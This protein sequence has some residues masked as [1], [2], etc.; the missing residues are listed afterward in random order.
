LNSLRGALHRAAA[1]NVQAATEGGDFTQAEIM[2]MTTVEELRQVNV[3][4]LAA[5]LM[6]GEL[7]QRIE[8]TSALTSHPGQYGSIREMA[9][10]QGISAAELSRTQALVNVIFPY[11][12]EHLGLPIMQVYEQIGKSNMTEL[13]PVLVCII[14]GEASASPAITQAA[15]RI[16]DD[17]AATVQAA[18]MELDNDGNYTDNDG[19]PRNLRTSVVGELLNDASHLNNREL[20]QRIRPERTSS[21]SATVTTVNGRK[22]FVAEMDEDQYTMLMRRV[23]ACTDVLFYNPATSLEARQV[24]LARVPGMRRIYELLT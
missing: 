11:I 24:E 22:L 18:G 10:D 14:T 19:N 4:D 21:I 13:I 17:T 1:A 2:A 12:Q 16:M 9:A 8:R 6:R 7:L 3:V 20:R 5:V 15:R 23:S